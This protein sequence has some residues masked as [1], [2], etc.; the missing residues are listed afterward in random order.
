M[1]KGVKRPRSKLAGGLQLFCQAGVQLAA[2]RSLDVV[3]QVQPVAAFY[4]LREEMGRYAHAA[5]VVELLDALTDEGDPDAVIFDLLVATLEGLD[6]GG[7]P[8]TLAQ[9]FELKLL[10]RLGYGP[11]MD[12]CV[13]CGRKVEGEEAGFS[14]PRGGVVCGRCRR[15]EGGSVLSPA[16]LRAMRELR[17]LAPE[18]LAK[19]RLSGAAREEVGRLMRAFEEYHLQRQLRSAE[20]LS[21]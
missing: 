8:A 16:A 13:S 3:T 15:A 9:G 12:V 14:A 21:R 2:G 4:H 5:Y 6:G 10:G 17:E 11:E 7:D 1:A 18:E 19:R 20:F